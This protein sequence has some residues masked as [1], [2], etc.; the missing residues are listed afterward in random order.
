MEDTNLPPVVQ[1][2]KEEKFFD[3]EKPEDLMSKLSD[4][5]LVKDLKIQAE[6]SCSNFSYAD[7]QELEPRGDFLITASSSMSPFHYMGK[8][9]NE[10]C[11]D[12]FI[13]KFAKIIGL[14]VDRAVLTDTFTGRFLHGQKFPFEFDVHFRNQ[15]RALSRLLPFIDKGIISFANPSRAYC[16]HCYKKLKDSIASATASLAD[17]SK[18]ELKYHFKKY[19]EESAL[20]IESPLYSGN[21]THPIS[22]VFLLEKVQLAKIERVLESKNKG[23]RKQQIFDIINDIYLKD[24]KRTVE[25]VLFDVDLSRHIKSV[26]TAGT[27]LENLYL[28]ELDNNRPDINNIESWENLRAID[29]P[30]IKELSVDEILIL[31]EEAQNSLPKFRQLIGQGLKGSGEASDKAIFDV[32]AELKEQLNEVEVE[33]NSLS[34]TKEK[35]YRFGMAGLALSFVVYSLYT[36]Q[37]I[38][39]A[40]SV[41][42]LLTTLAHLRSD[43]RE[44]DAKMAQ[45]QSKPAF[46][47]FKAKEI[48]QSKKEL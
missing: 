2:L 25:D 42:G 47:L 27:R 24:L 39:T 41:A 40:T 21:E 16:E 46:T 3:L 7:R 19:G 30:Y 5:G 29:L 34:L 37:A 31:R 32:V 48:L 43:E 33:I 1:I 17:D 10:R 35:R 8:C 26:F 4:S 23:K 44:C 14:Y 11:F 6:W 15:I 20:V 13:D 38:V 18:K 28:R 45:I 36:D 12:D 22:S 9:S